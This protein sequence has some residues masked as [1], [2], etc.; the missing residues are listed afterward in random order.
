MVIEKALVK[1]NSPAFKYFAANRAKWGAGDFFTSPGPR[2]LWGPVCNQMP[3]T[4]AL[5][6]EYSKLE[7]KI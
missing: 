3:M 5:N 1:L 2:Q 7:F 6:Q 4:V